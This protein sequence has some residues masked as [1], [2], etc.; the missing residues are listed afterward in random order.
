MQYMYL[1]PKGDL[2][3][4]PR[5]RI[6][7]LSDELKPTDPK[8]SDYVLVELGEDE[9]EQDWSIGTIIQGNDDYTDMRRLLYT[10]AGRSEIVQNSAPIVD[11]SPPLGP[12][13]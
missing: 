13:L 8:I 4:V 11:D 5:D 10:L 6:H 2:V 3:P 7:E 12:Y 1:N 9:E